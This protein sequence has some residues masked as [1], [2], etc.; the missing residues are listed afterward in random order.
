M[1]PLLELNLR[2]STL[3]LEA[4][5]LVAKERDKYTSESVSRV[6]QELERRG[7]TNITP[8]HSERVGAGTAGLNEQAYGGFW[9]RFAALWVDFLVFSPLAAGMVWADSYSRYA[10]AYFFL[11]SILVATFYNVYLVQ[12]FGGT[13]GKPLMHL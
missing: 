1:D 3:S 5:L 6:L 12:R 9:R 7:V 13:P 4:L 10:R 8:E 11:P 2:V